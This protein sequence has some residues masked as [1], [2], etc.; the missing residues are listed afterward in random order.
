MESRK[1]KGDRRHQTTR[2]IVF[3]FVVGENGYKTLFV[4]KSDGLME[5]GISKHIIPVKNSALDWLIHLF[6]TSAGCESFPR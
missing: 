4:R 5:R 6:V 2:L 1:C 3:T